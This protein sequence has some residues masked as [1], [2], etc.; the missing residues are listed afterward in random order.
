MHPCSWFIERLLLFFAKE[1]RTTSSIFAQILNY[2]LFA[3]INSNTVQK[4][5][6][7]GHIS[8]I[9]VKAASLK[10]LSTSTGF[11]FLSLR[12]Y[13]K[14]WEV[15]KRSVKCF[16]FPQGNEGLIVTEMSLRWNPHF[17]RIL[18]WSLRHFLSL[19]QLD[20][21]SFVYVLFCDKIAQIW[22]NCWQNLLNFLIVL[23]WV[24][25]HFLYK[26][27]RLF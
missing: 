21:N 20:S 13:L 19:F 4:G 18:F 25:P 22:R 10:G 5:L 6:L 17:I 2:R 9:W 11:K 16:F 14:L 27:H 1:N 24:R 23:A 7:L 26:M 8:S 3:P 12:G 15:R